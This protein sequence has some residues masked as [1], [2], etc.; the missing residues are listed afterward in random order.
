MTYR[1]SSKS[2]W[3]R[4]L[5]RQ[6]LL[7][8]GAAVTSVAALGQPIEVAQ[9]APFTGLAASD[10]R[11]LQAGI[12]AEFSQVNKAGGIAGRKLSLVSLDDKFNGEEF[13]RQ[14]KAVM[15]HK[16]VALLAPLGLD[17]MRKLLD[18]GLIE[19]NDIV[20]LDAI[21]GATP[22]RAPGHP[23][24]FHVRAGDREQIEK[25]LRHVLAL[26][27]TSMEVVVQDLRAGAA[28]VESA[29]KAVG[30]PKLKVHIREVAPKPGALAAAAADVAKS[31]AQSVLVLG[32]PPYM[33]EAV[34]AL[35]KAG[36]SKMV[37]ALSY[38]PAGLVLKLAGPDAARGVSIMQTFPNPMGQTL[39][40]HRQFQAAMKASAPDL[41]EYS[42]FHLEGYL[43]ARILVEALKRTPR[44]ISPAALAVSLRRMGELDMGG[45]RVDF[46][47]GNVG[48]HFTDIAV[49]APNGR[50][51][52]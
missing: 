51:M 19:G 11:D 29:Q 36:V 4:P 47:Q 49:V 38:L 23:R 25:A 8:A 7:L 37:F 2:A 44:T 14:F 10:A 32:S 26:G 35:R 6:V 46:S 20:V 3:L 17:A 31:G 48:S 24:L 28:D 45:F 42:S 52:Y 22:F 33:A 18:G 43:T 40:L 41:K 9:V 5:W 1:S 39:P 34:A 50:L 21:P 27:M 30:D 12:L 13:E 15:E 16:P